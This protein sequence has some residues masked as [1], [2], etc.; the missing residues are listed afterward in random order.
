MKL[1]LWSLPSF[2][3]LSSAWNL[4]S[5]HYLQLV[6]Y[7]SRG[8]IDRR[9]EIHSLFFGNTL[10]LVS[11]SEFLRMPYHILYF[12]KELILSTCYNIN[13]S[14]YTCYASLIASFKISSCKVIVYN[15]D[16]NAIMAV[17]HLRFLDRV[18]LPSS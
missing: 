11:F 6:A 3:S 5:D 2:G 15:V 18:Q 8:P 13:Q 16:K 4:S 14:E 7:R 1:V 17:W 12:M 9:I 10:T